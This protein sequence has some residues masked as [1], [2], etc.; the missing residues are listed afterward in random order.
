MHKKYNPKR[1]VEKILAVAEELFLTKGFDK[2]SMQ[3]I[4]NGLGMSKGAIFHHFNSKEEIFE[5]ISTKAAYHQMDEIVNVWLKELE[6]LKAK[7]KLETLFNRSLSSNNKMAFL[8]ATRVNDPRI[9]VGMMQSAINISAPIL[10]N[11]IREGIA[12]GS[13]QTDFPNE[14]AEVM[15]LLLNIWCDPIIFKCDIGDLEK[16]LCF[17]QH[18]SKSIGVDVISNEHIAKNIELT[19]KMYEVGNGNQ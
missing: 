15:L 16:R 18:L 14:I 13:I 2:T 1:T 19:K 5:A 3:D 7:D 17:L 8:M 10:A 11:V 12:D 6:G 9:I 4:V